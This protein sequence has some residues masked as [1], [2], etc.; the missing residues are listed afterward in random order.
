MAGKAQSKGGGVEKHGEAACRWREWTVNN[1]SGLQ[2]VG[3][4]IRC[5]S[6]TSMTAEG[7]ARLEEGVAAERGRS[8]AEEGQK[9][10][11]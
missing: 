10:E 5:K 2:R 4:K 7:E 6:K 9:S 3:F 11:F 8:E 1:R